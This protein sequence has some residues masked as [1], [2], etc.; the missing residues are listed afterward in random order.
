MPELRERVDARLA[1]LGRPARGAD[2]V[3]ITAS[4]GE[5]LFVTLL[6]LGV[7]P[8]GSLIGARGGAHQGLL[9]WMGIA[10]G[11]TVP[12]RPQGGVALY[13]EMRGG[14]SSNPGGGVDGSGAESPSIVVVG[15]GLFRDGTLRLD[16]RDI[17]VGSFDGLDGMSSFSLGFVAA[18]PDVVKRITTWKQ[19]SSICAPAPPQR[20]ALWAM[21][22]RP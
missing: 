7:F 19:A 20:A 4:E 3:L 8:E 15:D 11:E 14:D 2:S 22:V 9:D 16:P 12:S 1:S 13:R 10:I 17:V 18:E 21:G 6:G 5:S